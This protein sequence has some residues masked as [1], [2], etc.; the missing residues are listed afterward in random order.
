LKGLW[1][2]NGD[3][4]GG[5]TQPLVFPENKPPAP[6]ACF[7]TVTINNKTWNSPD[8]FKR[9]CVKWGDPSGGGYH[10]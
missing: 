7:F 4:L 5:I 2:L 1:G 10:P 3:D 6:V 8:G 9:H